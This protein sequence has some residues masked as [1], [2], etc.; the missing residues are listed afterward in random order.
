M[1]SRSSRSLPKETTATHVFDK[2]GLY[3]IMFCTVELSV[4]YETKISTPA[5]R[6]CIPNPCQN[7]ATCNEVK[8]GYECQC[9]PGYKGTDC[10]GTYW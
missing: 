4:V 1:P 7:G 3:G 10:D 6:H 8:D 9:T 2:V 5:E